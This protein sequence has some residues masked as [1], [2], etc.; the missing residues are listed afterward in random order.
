M[1]KNTLILGGIKSG[2]SRYAEK[3]ASQWLGQ[4]QGK[5]K[6]VV[7]ATAKDDEIHARIEHHKKERNPEFEVVEEP[8]FLGH[9]IS[10]IEDADCIVVD[11]LTLWITNLLLTSDSSTLLE[12]ERSSFLGAVKN[13]SSR[14]LIVSN[15]SNM[16]IIPIG[17]LS[18]RYCDEIGL[19]H[20]ELAAEC[21]EV[22]LLVAGIPLRV[23]S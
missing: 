12:T 13:S 21:D 8:I 16:G 7:T 20:Q 15:E 9:A 18:R 4:K 17:E 3:I 11:C 19:L 10:N 5:V 2:K 6:F 22:I 14:L 23:K 1:E